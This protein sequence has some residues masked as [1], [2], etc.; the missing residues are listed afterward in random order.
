MERGGGH[1]II[2]QK[3][4]ELKKP[5]QKNGN[6]KSNQ[7]KFQRKSDTNLLIFSHQLT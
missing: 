5:E 7:E 3:L 6:T 2:L 1:P 4:G